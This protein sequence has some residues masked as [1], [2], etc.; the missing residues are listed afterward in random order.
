MFAI[1]A[2]SLVKKWLQDVR[3]GNVL[4]SLR[5]LKVESLRGLAGQPLRRGSTAPDRD[6]LS[7]G[8]STNIIRARPN[9]T[10]GQQQLSKASTKFLQQ[11]RQ[12][13]PTC[14]YRML[15]LCAILCEFIR[16]QSLTSSSQAQNSRCHNSLPQ[17]QLPGFRSCPHPPQTSICQCN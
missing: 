2:R 11:I 3:D 15:Q 17:S 16:S 7:R 4:F 5:I 12:D 14:M 10:S 6:F 13:V 9:S 1:Q 8:S